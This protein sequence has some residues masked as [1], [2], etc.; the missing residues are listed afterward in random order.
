MSCA[1]SSVS[2]QCRDISHTVR[3][4]VEEYLGWI[5]FIYCDITELFS[6]LVWTMVLNHFHK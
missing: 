5:D 1:L 3:R 4:P 2:D 6:A